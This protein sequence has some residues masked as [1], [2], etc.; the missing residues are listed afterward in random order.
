MFDKT[1][2]PYE[3]HHLSISFRKAFN[4]STSAANLQ[5]SGVKLKKMYLVPLFTI[6]TYLMFYFIPWLLFS[7]HLVHHTTGF[8]A[9]LVAET[10]DVITGTVLLVD[11]LI[12]IWL[13]R[14]Y[15]KAIVSLCSCCCCCCG[16]GGGGGG[17]G[18]RSSG[19][20]IAKCSVKSNITFVPR[21]SRKVSYAVG[22]ACVFDVATLRV[23]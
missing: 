2:A 8:H 5:L 21:S 10:F 11:P 13:T 16:D 18:G 9:F 23:A 22:A 7:I 6:T 4:K 15:R 19:G 20:E 12:Y 14:K 3:N 17:G 1:R